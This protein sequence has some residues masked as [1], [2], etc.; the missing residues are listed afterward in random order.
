MSVY[1]NLQLLSG[2]PTSEFNKLIFDQYRRAETYQYSVVTWILIY[3]EFW[4]LFQ[5]LNRVGLL[6]P[7]GLQ[8]SRL[9]CPWDSRDKNSG[10]GCH[11][12]LQGIF[13][14]QELN[15]DLLH[16]RQMLYRL[17][18]EGNLPIMKCICH[19]IF[20]I[21]QTVPFLTLREVF[22]FLA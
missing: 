13:W 20:I 22:T 3:Y 16:C 6:Q 5:L 21:V 4:L 10:V 11:F 7:H 8:P 19:I 15:P 2:I 17:S 9:L 18:Y 12:L 1:F 14:T